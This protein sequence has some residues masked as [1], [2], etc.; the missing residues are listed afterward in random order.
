M[1]HKGHE[2]RGYL[3]KV[4]MVK[5]IASMIVKYERGVV[6]SWW[7]KLHWERF[8]IN[9]KNRIFVFW[10]WW[11]WTRFNSNSQSWYWGWRGS[12]QVGLE[13]LHQ[14]WSRTILSLS[15]SIS[16]DALL[17][18]TVVTKSESPFQTIKARLQHPLSKLLF[19]KSHLLWIAAQFG[20]LLA[21]HDLC[22]VIN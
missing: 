6:W 12:K 10:E 4:K 5:R 7:E 14:S 8:T 16:G 20:F 17:K 1:W 13:W 18:V 21:N 2:N 15:S 22:S 9:Y 3:M 11:C 19:T